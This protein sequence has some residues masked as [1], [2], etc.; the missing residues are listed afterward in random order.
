MSPSILLVVHALPYEGVLLTLGLL[1]SCI[2]DRV[3]KLVRASLQDVKPRTS[4]PVVAVLASRDT[5]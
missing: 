4:V 1:F 2:V 5:M 3:A